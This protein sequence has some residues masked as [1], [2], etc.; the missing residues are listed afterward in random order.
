MYKRPSLRFV[1]VVLPLLLTG[2]IASSQTSQTKQPKQATQAKQNQTP[3]DKPRKVKREPDNA[4]TQWIKE[5][6]SLII[7]PAE[8][9]AFAKL[10]TNEEREQ[11]I[12]IFW[13]QR[14]P[15]PDT[16]ENEYREQYYERMAYANEHFSS[17]KPGW[18]TDRGRIFVKF[19]KPDDIES[20][21]SGGPYQQ[22]G[23]EGTDSIT[24][25]PFEKWFYRYIAGVGSGIEIE[26]VD[27]TG[28]GEYR[29]ARNSG[30][31]NAQAH[32]PGAGRDPLELG[33]LREP[34]GPFA[35]IERLRDLENP[36][37]IDRKNPGGGSIPTPIIDDNPL[38]FSVR[39]DFFKLSETRVLTAF[40]VQTDNKDLVFTDSGGL[41]TARLNIFGR[42]ITPTDRR[43]GA[44]EDSVVTTAT[45]AELASTKERASAYSKVVPLE[46]GRYRA[47]VVVRDII[48]GAT[49][50]RHFAFQ[51]PRYD[52]NKLS[53]SSMILAAKLESMEGRLAADQFMIGQTK[54]IPN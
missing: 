9:E 36:P 28:S 43:V 33:S 1:I 5:D 20:H 15:D 26:F 4:Y 13:R 39:A 35:I 8:R 49:G 24:A 12:R 11:F 19:G 18:M 10:K 2:S 17:G 14:D 31:K 53:T 52:A 38:D 41:Q 47:D 6:V 3:D 30:E 46:P 34:G 42:I 22:T 16:E 37:E 45:A 48:S 21:P 25:Y 29:F 51:V 7:T 50:V 23:Y 44:F 54:V 40:T 32:L 27:P